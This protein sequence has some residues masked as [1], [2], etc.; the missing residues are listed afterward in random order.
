[1]GL[2]RE[3][4]YAKTFFSVL[5]RSICEVRRE[6]TLPSTFHDGCKPTMDWLCCVLSSSDALHCDVIYSHRCGKIGSI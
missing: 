6:A 4:R 2:S 5:R 3:T 1:M